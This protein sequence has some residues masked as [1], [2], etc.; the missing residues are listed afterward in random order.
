[1]KFTQLIGQ[2]IL[3]VFVGFL[4][5]E[6]WRMYDE[7]RRVERVA[8]DGVRTTVRVDAVTTERKTWRDYLSNSKY[9]HFRYDGKDYTLRYSQDSIYLQSGISIP[10]YYSAS[11]G[12]FV[13]NIKGSRSEEV[14]RTSPLV[15][16]TVVRLFSPTH[17]ILFFCWGLTLLFIIFALG[18]LA[19]LT[20]MPVLWT[21]QNRVG[22]FCAVCLAVYISYNAFANWRY[23]S[24]LRQGVVQSVKVKD[25][26]KTM[27]EHNT[28]PSDRIFFEVYRARV[29]FN[30]EPRI[31]AVGRKD[32][33]QVHPGENLTVLYNAGMD[34]MM[35]ANYH[36]PVVD[37]VFPFVVWGIVLFAI[38]QRRK[39]GKI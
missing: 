16:F 21:V 32:F 23:A 37:I 28:D 34:D 3:L 38:F 27:D 10:V 14:V 30:G 19:T 1:M 22:G 26:Y 13:Q 2:L 18:F 7:Q 24:Q 29:L 9:V 36:M 35:G 8:K 17:A 31:I 39:K 12:E 33:E 6:G 25:I 4:A 15:K 20:G 11:A 5:R